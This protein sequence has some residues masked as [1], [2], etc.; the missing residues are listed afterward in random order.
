MVG[1]PFR[2]G[3]GVKDAELLREGAKGTSLYDGRLIEPQKDYARQLLTH[4]NLS[5]KRPYT[6][7][8]AV[9][10]VEI[11]NENAVNL[12]FR[13]PSAFYQDELT[14]LYNRWLTKHRSTAEISSFERL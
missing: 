10:I 1:K 14:G 5:T 8:P 13:A 6:D 3:D 2:A 4:R 12:G 7:D 9:G 11:N